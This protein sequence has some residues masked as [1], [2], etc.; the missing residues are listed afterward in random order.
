[1]FGGTV[2]GESYESEERDAKDALDCRLH[3]RKTCIN[4]SQGYFKSGPQS[5]VDDIY[6]EIQLFLGRRKRNHVVHSPCCSEA[7]TK[8]SVSSLSETISSYL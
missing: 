1:M 5:I 2:C 6:S 7:D 4:D 8:P 3:Y